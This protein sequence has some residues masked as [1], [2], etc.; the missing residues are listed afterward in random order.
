[1][2]RKPKYLRLC[3]WGE[4]GFTDCSWCHLVPV[5]L[6]ASGERGGGRFLTLGSPLL[7]LSSC[8]GS[9]SALS[10]E[11]DSLVLEYDL[12]E[13]YMWLNTRG[14]GSRWKSKEAALLRGVLTISEESSWACVEGAWT[15]ESGLSLNAGFVSAVCPWADYLITVILFYPSIN[16]TP[17]LFFLCC[18]WTP[19]H[20]DN[21][22]DLADALQMPSLHFFLLLT[23]PLIILETMLQRL[24]PKRW[25]SEIMVWSLRDWAI[26]TDS[27]F[28][29][30]TGSNAGLL[31][32][33]HT[34]SR[35]HS[36]YHRL[37]SCCLGFVSLSARKLQ[38]DRNPHVPYLPWY[39][40][41]PHMPWGLSS[42]LYM[43]EFIFKEEILAN[44]IR[45][46]AKSPLT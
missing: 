45:K 33:E 10:R 22:W 21:A 17:D 24:E 38:E 8:A 18:D 44:T 35:K 1:M 2:S 29:K 46:E 23:G 36:I 5:F 41:V 40:T 11:F 12:P 32:M 31:R 34:A 20:C 28:L 27:W 4:K 13:V 26:W 7:S 42:Y 16:A 6:G 15:L 43:S 30:E 14:E 19:W 9:Q 25:K 37:L 39:P 3:F